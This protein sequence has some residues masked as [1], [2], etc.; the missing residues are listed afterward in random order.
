[1]FTKNLFVITANWF[2]NYNGLGANHTDA[3]FAHDCVHAVFGI[4]VS[5]KEEELVLNLTNCLIG[6]ETN[7]KMEQAIE[8]AI[9]SVN[10]DLLIELSTY[11]EATFN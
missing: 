10:M 4:G 5:L 8:E 7:P 3:A 6:Q 2:A 9:A 1:M 11:L